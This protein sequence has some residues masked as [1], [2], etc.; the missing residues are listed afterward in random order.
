MTQ[1]PEGRLKLAHRLRSKIHI[2][3][4]SYHFDSR[5]VPHIS[6]PLRDM[7]FHEPIPL[8]DLY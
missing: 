7:G 4:H 1:T 5:R 2:P 6:S 8:K 3:L